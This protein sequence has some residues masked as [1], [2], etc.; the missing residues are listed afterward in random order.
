MGV[1]CVH[2]RSEHCTID[3]VR[4]LHAVSL[5]ARLLCHAHLPLLGLLHV[6]DRLLRYVEG[7]P[8]SKTLFL[9]KPEQAQVSATVVIRG[10]HAYDL[11]REGSVFTHN[12]NSF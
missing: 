8:K 3:Q 9:W 4:A 12:L 5:L 2:T 11:I 6:R 10:E 1:R 7:Q